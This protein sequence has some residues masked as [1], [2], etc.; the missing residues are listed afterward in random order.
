M[1]IAGIMTLKNVSLENL[2]KKHQFIKVDNCFGVH[3]ILLKE[4]VLI[5]PLL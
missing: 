2:K 4:L 1:L 3:Y 5:R